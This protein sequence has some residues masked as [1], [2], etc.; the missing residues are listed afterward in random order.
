[1]PVFN[2]FL[3]I[4]IA[5]D[6]HGRHFVPALY[7]YEVNISPLTALLHINRDI[8]AMITDGGHFVEVIQGQYLPASCGRQ[9]PLLKGLLGNVDN[10]DIP[11]LTKVFPP[12]RFVHD[13]Q[14]GPKRQ[15]AQPDRKDIFTPGKFFLQGGEALALR[16]R[17]RYRDSDQKES[18]KVLH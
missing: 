12:A 13:P 5:F 9:V 14:Y 2:Q 15:P 11:D 8:L 7:E 18:D 10:P 4:E 1:M 3:R 16:V 17:G 6:L